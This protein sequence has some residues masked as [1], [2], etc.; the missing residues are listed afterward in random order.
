MDW[1]VYGTLTWLYVGSGGGV[2][3][4]D[5]DDDDHGAMHLT[6]RLGWAFGLRSLDGDAA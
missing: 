2:G 5:G 6:Y 1:G 3:I 4:G